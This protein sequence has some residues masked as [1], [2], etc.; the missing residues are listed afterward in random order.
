MKTSLWRLMPWVASVALVAACSD[1]PPSGP[2]PS[3]DVPGDVAPDQPGDAATDTPADEPSPDVPGDVAP[4]QPGDVVSEQPDDVPGDAPE[5][6]P[7]DAPADA[8][9]DAPDDVPGDAPPDV[10]A[11][12][13]RCLMGQIECLGM[14]VDPMTDMANC[15]ACGTT[16]AGGSMCVMG[17][18]TCPMGQTRCGTGASA[19]CVDT[20]SSNMNCGACGMA[21]PTGQSCMAGAC[22]PDCAA[23]RTRCGAGASAVCTDTQTDA[24]NCGACGTACDMGLVCTAGRCGCAMGQLSCMGRCVDGQTDNMN[25]GDCGNAC[26]GGSTCSMGR[27]ACPMGQQLCGMGASATCIDTQSNNM[28]CGACGNACGTGQT[29][30]AG[31][32][33]CAAGQTFCGSACVDTASDT[34]NCGTCGNACGAGLV[35]T[36]G[37]CEC[38]AGQTSCGGTC[39][40]TMTSNANCGAC[41]S[42]C[43]MAQTCAGGVCTCPSGLTRCGTSCVDART[44]NGNCG[45]CGTTCTGGRTCQAGVCNCPAGQTFCGGTCVDTRADNGNCGACGRACPS[46][47]TCQSGACNCPPGLTLCAGTCVDIRTNGANCGRCGNMCSSTTSCTAGACV[48]GPPS[49]DT[50]AGAITIDMSSPTASLLVNTMSAANNTTGPCRCTGGHDVFYRFTLARPEIVYADTI[51]TSWDTSLFLQTSTGANVTDA[52]MAGGAACNDDGAMNLG[53][54]IGLQSQIAAYLPAGTYLLVL[55]GCSAG[56]AT[57]HFQHLP[58]S[59]PGLRFG[60]NAGDSTTTS[61]TLTGANGLTSACC[62]TGPEIT[63]WAVTCPTFAGGPLA[64]TVT[65]NG[66]TNATLDQRSANRGAVAS[67]VG[68]A[69]CGANT[70]IATTLPAGAALH[71]LVVDSCGGGGPFNLAVT[72]GACPSGTTLCA[73]R[74]TATA[75]DAQNC[76]A[77]GTVCTGGRTC[78]GGSCACPA[79]TAFCGGACISTAG[80]VNNCG[81]CGVRCGPTQVC[82]GGA[83]REAVTGLSFRIDSL[84]ASGCSAIEHNTVTGDDRG[85]IAVSNTN[86]FYTGDSATGRFSLTNLSG[87]TNVGRQYDAMVSNLRTGKVYVFGSS[88]AAPIGYG[89][90]TA[91]HLIEIDGATGALTSSVIA[92]SSPVAMSYGTGLFSGYDRLGV[93]TGTR[94]VH[95][96][97][98]S[99]RVL[100]LGATPNPSHSG[101]ESWAYWG[102]LEF[103]GGTL[104]IDYV[105]SGPYPYRTISR[106]SVPTGT[107]ST[108][109]TFT[110]LSDMCSFT[111]QPWRNRW[112]FHHEGNSQFRSGDETIGFCNATW[113]SPSDTFRLS[114]LSNSSCVSTDHVA[115]TGDDRGG[116]AVSSTGAFYTGDTATG[117]FNAVDLGNGTRL[118]SPAQFDGLVQNLKTGS[119]Y[120]LAG[121]AGVL[122]YGGGTVTALLEI[123]GNTGGLTG[124][125]VTL[126]TPI[127]VGSGSGLFSG[128]D[129]LVILNGSRAYDI[130]LP[131]GSV[132]DMGAIGV[133]A[134]TVCENWAFWGTAEF[135]GGTL[136]VDYVQ[137]TNT[138]ARMAVP[139]G[140][141]ST[142]ASFPSSA[143][144]SGL[145]DMCS[146]TFSPLRNRW[147]WHHEGSS[148]LRGSTTCFIDE[149]IGSCGAAY[150]NP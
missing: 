133:P 117:R 15:G 49:N 118:T 7:V 66:Q 95:I 60:A 130:A 135:F 129:R 55:S 111:V 65:S 98:P 36:A 72:V 5:D 68:A 17:T 6:V 128:W 85:G 97:L 25:C 21:C 76:G 14:C 32:C 87:G 137:N 123:D 2:G 148:T 91:T 112:Y 51:G 23:P 83:C 22:V 45:G 150:T 101:C 122:P 19:T 44:D 139:A 11:D 34:S 70:S 149:T 57:I 27:C 84:T 28:N 62:S 124:R 146:F 89:G 12:V 108:L 26:V 145:S 48:A 106:M 144:F 136:Y 50:A 132:V 104:Y 142:L 121:A 77:C 29:C 94:F 46:G 75:T 61:N 138:I 18:C 140:T 52:G 102:T 38:P 8:P 69:S 114:T 63:Y 105:S 107:V 103:F 40:N 141:I 10:P 99:G 93:H 9:A 73:G 54:S 56:E 92:L 53:C 110:S 143:S 81:G 33:E 115:V 59:N 131:S 74:C 39:V 116:I 134:H 100:D 4:D 96:A 37:R 24:M 90:G 67:C 127:S 113:S 30:R 120:A 88:A 1:N 35:C 16:C 86:V 64:A 126:S 3:S 41:G 71:T 20:Q 58:A 109:A 47:Q 82:A 80:D 79:G 43:G 125:S 147:Y 31:R 119:V 42:A 13:S 78:A